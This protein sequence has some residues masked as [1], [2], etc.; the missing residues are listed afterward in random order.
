MGICVAGSTLLPIW[1]S[2]VTGLVAYPDLR[3]PV[4][5]LAKG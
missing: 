1:V 5:G 2:G 3:L 4:I